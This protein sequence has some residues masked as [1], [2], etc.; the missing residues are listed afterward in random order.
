MVFFTVIHD[1]E[2]NSAGFHRARLQHAARMDLSKCE[3]WL[4]IL[5]LK[6]PVSTIMLMNSGIQSNEMKFLPDD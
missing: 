3:N 6:Q 4:Y 1:N 2:R 5:Y